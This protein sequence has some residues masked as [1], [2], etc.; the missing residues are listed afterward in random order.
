MDSVVIFDD[1]QRAYRDFLQNKHYPKLEKLSNWGRNRYFFSQ[2]FKV[3]DD[4]YRHEKITLIFNHR[5]Y[6]LDIREAPDFMDQDQYMHWLQ[7]Y[8]SE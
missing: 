1:I 4:Q 6:C 3:I 5:I 8:F 2:Y 7:H